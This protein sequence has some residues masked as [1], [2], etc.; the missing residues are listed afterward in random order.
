MFIKYKICLKIVKINN[1]EEEY[2]W[3]FVEEW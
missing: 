3:I 2:G 1:I